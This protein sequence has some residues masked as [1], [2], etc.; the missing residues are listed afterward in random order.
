MRIV[1]EKFAWPIQAGQGRV[2]PRRAQADETIQAGRSQTDLRTPGPFDAA[3]A[4]ICAAS[5]TIS[6]ERRMNS[7]ICSASSGWRLS[8]ARS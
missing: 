1:K 6:I 3:G 4:Y 2:G 5:S 7:V 8:S